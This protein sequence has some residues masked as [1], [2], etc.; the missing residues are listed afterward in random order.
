MAKK[1]KKPSMTGKK[2]KY[3]VELVEDASELKKKG[4]GGKHKKIKNGV[5]NSSDQNEEEIIQEDS[6]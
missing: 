3:D 6:D 4:K 2:F 1:K 5:M